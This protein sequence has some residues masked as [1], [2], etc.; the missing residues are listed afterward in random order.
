M[1]A[2]MSHEEQQPGVLRVLRDRDEA[3]AFYNKIARVYDFLSEASEGPIRQFG[4]EK[5]TVKEGE[6]VLEIGF[7]TGTS[8]VELAQMVGSQGRVFGIDIADQMLDVSQEKERT[9][10]KSV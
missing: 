2:I 1:K 8:L 10:L 6:R 7:G 9:V 3:T 5:L 4:L